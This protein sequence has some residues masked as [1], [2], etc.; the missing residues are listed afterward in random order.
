MKPLRFGLSIAVAAATIA[1]L[2]SYCWIP[3]QCNQA[4]KIAESAILSATRRGNP[5]DM[6][7][8]VQRQLPSLERWIALQ[9]NDLDLLVEKAAT[10]RLVKRYAE[11]AIAYRDA[12]DLEP[13]PELYE[14]L[15][16][17]FMKLDRRQEAIDAYE[18]ASRFTRSRPSDTDRERRRRDR[19][20]W[21]TADAK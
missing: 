11:A 21:P 16:T 6:A 2:W 1:A 17:V 12:I 8:L 18:H 4:K 13:R 5:Q 7:Y 9:P 10:L 15:G 20:N 19:R 3:W 14:N